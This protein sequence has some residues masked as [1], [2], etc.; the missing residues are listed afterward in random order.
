MPGLHGPQDDLTWNRLEKYIDSLSKDDSIVSKFWL[1]IMHQHM[2][3]LKTSRA[4][5]QLCLNYRVQDRMI[6]TNEEQL[7]H[8]SS[9]KQRHQSH[10]DIQDQITTLLGNMTWKKNKQVQLQLDHDN[11]QNARME[12]IFDASLTPQQVLLPTQSAPGTFLSRHHA[13]HLQLWSTD[14]HDWKKDDGGEPS[15]ATDVGGTT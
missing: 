11:E 5:K 14:I 9:Y 4:L 6:W 13:S 2:K 15:T 8:S 3:G 1:M 10:Q 12:E 7:E